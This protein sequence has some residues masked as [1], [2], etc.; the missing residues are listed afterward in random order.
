MREP[1]PATPD[2]VDDL[3]DRPE[4][5]PERTAVIC[6]MTAEGYEAYVIA[7][8]FGLTLDQVRR[9]ISTPAERRYLNLIRVHP[10]YVAAREAR[11]ARWAARWQ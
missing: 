9:L 1:D 3:P 8:R 11:E 7:D 5:M 4:D 6:E 10:Q 2:V